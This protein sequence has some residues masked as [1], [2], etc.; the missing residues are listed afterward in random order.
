VEEITIFVEVNGFRVE[1]KV[2]ERGKYTRDD[3]T[4]IA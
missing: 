3:K 2:D 1:M 4:N